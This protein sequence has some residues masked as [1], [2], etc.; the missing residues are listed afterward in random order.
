MPTPNAHANHPEWRSKITLATLALALAGFVAPASA[1]DFQYRHLVRGLTVPASPNPQ[2]PQPATLV[3]AAEGY[4]SWNDGTYAENCKSYRNPVKQA[5]TGATGDGVY[6]ILIGTTPVDV[7][8]DM[9]QD[10]GGWT[11]VRH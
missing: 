7:Y 1:A 9:T 3:L 11:L 6:R 8:C 5:Y 10:G 2:E 4:R